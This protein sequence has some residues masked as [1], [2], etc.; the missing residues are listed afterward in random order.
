MRNSFTRQNRR[1]GFTLI[2]LLVVIAIIAILAAMLLPA[3]AAAKRKAQTAGCVNNI[4][5]M[6]LADIMYAGD[7][8]HG[9]PDAA[10]S[11]STGSWFINFGAYY[12]K[13]TN[14]LICPTTTQPQVMQNNFW[15]NAVTP[16][17]KTD[18]AGNGAAFFG[19]Y[20]INGWF[21][22]DSTGSVGAGDAYTANNGLFGPLYYLHDSA[23]RN[24]SAAPVFSDGVWVDCWPMES[25]SA[26]HDLRGTISATGSSSQ[27]GGFSSS[28]FGGK[29]MAR[30][31]VSRH[32][33][34]AGAPNSWALPTDNPPGGVNIGL[35]DGHVEFS[36]IPHLWSYAWHANWGGKL[37]TGPG[38]PANPIKVGTPF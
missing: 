13:G 2:E 16:W 34:N 1:S 17:C 11:G 37:G 26:C 10:P 22:T 33:C 18:Y 6:T 15:G 25:D 5:Q 35:F 31:A 8:G 14:V 28:G 7:F 4:K 3:L 21:S 23:V 12:S 30:T 29:E 19:S 36:K 20:I 38:A 32:A 27:N 9:I 24:P